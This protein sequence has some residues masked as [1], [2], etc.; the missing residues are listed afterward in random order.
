MS[1]LASDLFTDLKVS[2]A[3]FSRE[4]ARVAL[5]NDAAMLEHVDAVRV[6]QGE[7]DILLAEKHGN[8]GRLP[9]PFDRLWK[10]AP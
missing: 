1:E 9:Q 5:P 7:G 8:L 2:R 3:G 10:S 6:G 4:A